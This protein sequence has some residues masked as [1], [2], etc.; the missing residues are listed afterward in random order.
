MRLDD[1]GARQVLRRLG[2][3]AHHQ[4]RPEREVRRVEDGDSNSG[5]A[6][7]HLGE[8]GARRADDRRDAGI[9][10]GLDVRHHCVRRREVDHDVGLPEI[11]HE[12]VAGRLERRPEHRADLAA[13]PVEE[14]P[15]RPIVTGR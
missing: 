3:E 12:L 1:L 11:V 7:P 4:H 2:G 13:A 6:L 10:G 14:D 5:G 9:D 15:H 8:I